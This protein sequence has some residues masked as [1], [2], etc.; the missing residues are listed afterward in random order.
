MPNFFVPNETRNFF[1]ENATSAKEKREI[2]TLTESEL[3]PVS[4]NL[5]TELYKSVVEK[6]H[7]DF[8]DIPASKGDITKYKG[9]VDMVKC[10]DIIS[11]IATKNNTKITEVEIVQKAIANIVALRDQFTKGFAI[12]NNFL[13]LQYNTLVATC[14]EATSSVIASY[15]DYI[16]RVDAVEFTIINTKTN[17]GGL[18]VSN[19]KRFNDL[20]ASG[21]YAKMCNAVVSGATK[22]IITE[23][24]AVITVAVL[25]TLVA[26]VILLKQIVFRMYYNRMKLS[27]Y[28]KMQAMFLEMNK[29]TIEAS[30]SNIPPA[31]KK[32]IIKKQ[33]ELSAKLLK[34][35]DKIKVENTMADSTSTKEL[36]KDN[37]TYTLDAIK[38]TNN[39]DNIEL[40]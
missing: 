17:S 34:L 22:S 10:L 38:T 21:E 12:G 29:A 7:I 31:K 5:V 20:V 11:R 14:V 4:N 37:S 35:S 32:T 30:G 3:Q 39:L 18:C 13:V 27:E 25:T 26:V 2:M 1:L 8:E 36:K 9:Y 24:V 23:S 33:Q 15:V 19:L 40:L 16:K 6:S 28:L